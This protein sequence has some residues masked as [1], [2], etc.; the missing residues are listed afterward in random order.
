V[1]AQEATRTIRVHV[2][3]NRYSEHDGR[4][5]VD[6]RGRSGTVVGFD[7]DHENS[8]EVELDHL[9]YSAMFAPFELEVIP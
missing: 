7:P 3:D 5:G 4:S 2:I 8:V 9:G 1:N 6:Y